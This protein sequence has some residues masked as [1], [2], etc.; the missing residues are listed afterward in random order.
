[1]DCWAGLATDWGVS[2]LKREAKRASSSVTSISF[3][4]C[5]RDFPS[6]KEMYCSL[7]SFGG[8]VTGKSKCERVK[9]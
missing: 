1:M 8:V 3:T 2:L 6:R 9:F 7:V 4:I 5:S